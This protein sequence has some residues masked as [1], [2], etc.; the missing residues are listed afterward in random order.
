MPILTQPIRVP[1]I[2]DY[3]EDNPAP[4]PG[5]VPTPIKEQGEALA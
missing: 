3:L 4:E 5:S 1:D 2:D